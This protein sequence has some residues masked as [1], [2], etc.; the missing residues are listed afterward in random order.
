MPLDGLTQYFASADE[1]HTFRVDLPDGEY[2]L[3]LVAP[4][5]AGA[6][7]PTLVQGNVATLGGK[8]LVEARINVVVTKRSLDVMVGGQGTWALS[9]LIVRP[10]APVIAHL[11]PPG[12]QVEEDP[13]VITATA[14]APDGIRSMT[15]RY[16]A[17]HRWRELQMDG[18]GVAFH[19]AVPVADLGNGSLA[20][21]LVAK[22]MQGRTSRLSGL[23][24]PVARGFRRPRIT[25]VESPGVWSPSDEL[26]LRVALENG[27]FAREVRLHYREADQN[28]D[29]RLM[30]LRGG[31]SGDYEFRV[32]TRYL[33]VGYDLIYYF[34]LVDVL[35]GGSFHPDP[36][37]EARYF[38]CGPEGI[39]AP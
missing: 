30:K 38:I 26:E 24:A 34:E 2:E 8:A 32:A 37:D 4:T 31:R 19:A 5:A 28:R 23:S 36:F 20:Y 16:H 39:Q 35:G 22:D 3:T 14:T 15:L 10:L 13:V 7:T 25:F 1:P 9:G 17:S 27:E 12:I 33:D 6:I 29:F 18:D 11:P 21:E